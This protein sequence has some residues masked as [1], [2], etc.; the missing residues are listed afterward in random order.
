MIFGS[1]DGLR[2]SQ[3]LLFQPGSEEEKRGGGEDVTTGPFARASKATPFDLVL[4]LPILQLRLTPVKQNTLSL[5]KDVGKLGLKAGA[6][7]HSSSRPSN[8]CYHSFDSCSRFLAA[9]SPAP[10]MSDESRDCR[11]PKRVRIHSANLWLNH[12]DF[13]NR[14]QKQ[15]T[16]HP[17]SLPFEPFVLLTLPQVQPPEGTKPSLSMYHTLLPF[18]HLPPC[19]RASSNTLR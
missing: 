17:S 6:A 5:K 3:L 12:F 14:R 11:K 13:A 19:S 18:S 15:M 7:N 2:S 16:L 8:Y 4:H 10:K 9:R 1:S